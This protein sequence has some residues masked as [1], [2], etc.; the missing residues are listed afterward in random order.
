VIAARHTRGRENSG[1]PNRGSAELL[2]VLHYFRERNN[3]VMDNSGGAII[4][5]GIIDGGDNKLRGKNY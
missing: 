1:R 4:E 5:R 3:G 2:H